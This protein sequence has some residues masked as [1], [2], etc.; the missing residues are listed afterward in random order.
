MFDIVPITTTPVHSGRVVSMVDAR[1]D[2]GDYMGR[3]CAVLSG[4]IG[5]KAKSKSVMDRASA[6][7][8]R[9]VCWAGKMHLE[10]EFVLAMVDASL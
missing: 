9:T 8:P 1:L 2:A 10:G 3:L 4:L 7:P 5:S 6:A